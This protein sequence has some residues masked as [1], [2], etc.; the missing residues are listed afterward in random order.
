MAFSGKIHSEDQPAMF[1]T[2][3]FY[4]ADISSPIA[5]LYSVMQKALRR[6]TLALLS[7]EFYNTF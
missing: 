5:K 6:I 1:K 7:T 3:K 4:T 2:K